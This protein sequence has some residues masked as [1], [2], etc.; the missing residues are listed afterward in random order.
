[1]AEENGNGE[2]AKK[3]WLTEHENI[4]DDLLDIKAVLL[5]EM[6]SEDMEDKGKKA[7]LAEKKP[8]AGNELEIPHAQP[9]SDDRS[10][11]SP[12]EKAASKPP[13]LK[14]PQR[15]D[16]PDKVHSEPTIKDLLGVKPSKNQVQTGSNGPRREDTSAIPKHPELTNYI[17]KVIEHESKIKRRIF[18]KEKQENRMAREEQRS[19]KDRKIV[20]K[21]GSEKDRGRDVDMDDRKEEKKPPQAMKKKILSEDIDR[22][23]PEKL[24]IEEKEDMEELS[25]ADSKIEWESNK[26]NAGKKGRKHKEEYGSD[27]TEQ[28]VEEDEVTSDESGD[29]TGKQRFFRIKKFF[30]RR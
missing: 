12:D 1:M 15:P 29:H 19:K 14:K 2:H 25:A 7:D 21:D 22:I 28:E 10:T 16:E 30:R 5:N 18:E 20:K 6:R 3:D 8:G 23:L 13:T 4:Q 27:R 17:A 11:P 24:K 26:S 9:I